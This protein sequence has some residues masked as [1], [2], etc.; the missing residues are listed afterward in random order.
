MTHHTVQPF[1]QPHS[2]LAI[3]R[4]QRLRLAAMRDPRV[5]PRH[6]APRLREALADSP[7][8]L[9]HG[10][11]QC[12]KTTLARMIG[13]AAGY[14]YFTFDDAV[15]LTSAVADPA[16]FVAELPDRTILDEV[17]RVPALFSVLKSAVDRHRTPGRFLL[18][19]SAN[20]LLVP[21]LSDSLA[22]R[23]AIVRLHPL[24]QAELAARRP[25]FLDALFRGAFKTRT[26]PRLGR[27]LADLLVA[28][29]YPAAR[30]RSSARRRAEWYRDY[31]ETI[32]QRD[33]RDLARI[34]ALDALPR[35]LAYTV[36]GLVV[37]LGIGWAA[38][39]VLGAGPMFLALPLNLAI[40][41]TLFLVGG[42]GLG[43]DIGFEVS[44]S[45]E[46]ARVAALEK[47]EPPAV[48]PTAAAKDA[49]E[50]K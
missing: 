10:P 12:G 45:R 21:K 49:E 5:Y 14:T 17:Q 30:A 4:T 28:G 25:K 44:L 1:N 2:N 50:P 29:G 13:D 23:M 20:V 35:L 27:Q 8:V 18:T 48:A 15:T 36:I 3:S 24:A 47:S 6:L 33:V 26:F 37:V 19:G 46:R 32:V 34:S 39:A 31:I 41:V 42:W 40:C 43:R 16:G 38:P 9:L 11:R 22:G 7:V